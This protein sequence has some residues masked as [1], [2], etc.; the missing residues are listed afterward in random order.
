MMTVYKTE[1]NLDNN[2]N[3]SD[4]KV[5]QYEKNSRSNRFHFIDYGLSIFSQ[6]AFKDFP[7]NT[8]FD[9]SVVIQNLIK[10][11]TLAG[12]EVYN[13]FY[14]IG[15]IQGMQELSEYLRSNHN[16]FF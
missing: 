9:L 16:D 4:G 10:K 11:Q 13:R 1:P 3:F 2:L 6:E 12:F 15:S 14:E 8:N 7:K 5:I